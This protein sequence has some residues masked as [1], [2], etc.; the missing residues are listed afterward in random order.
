MALEIARSEAG[1]GELI[2][3]TGDVDLYS[4]PQLREAILK[5]IEKGKGAVGVALGAVSYMDSSGVATLVEG[6]KACGDKKKPF[7]LVA[8]SPQVMKVLELSRLH[9]VFEIRE[10]F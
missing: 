9:S 3:A 2:T 7:V 8:P 10:E 4:S 1:P 6:F 5:A